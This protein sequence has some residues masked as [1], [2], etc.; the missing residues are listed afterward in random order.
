M[1]KVSVLVL[2]ILIVSAASLS[3][4]TGKAGA[5]AAFMQLNLS[6]RIMGMGGAFGAV[7]DD[8]L[9]M[10]YN[11]AGA[12]QLKMNAVS[13]SYRHMDFDRKLGNVCAS[14]MA[15]EEA[16]IAVG[17]I[18]AGDGDWVGRDAEGSVTNEDL[19]YSDN[20]LAV[21]FARTF[22]DMIM[23]GA[24]GKY[25]ITK[26]ANISSNTVGFDVGTMM[27]LNRMNYLENSKLFDQI[28]IGLTVANL[29]ATHRW[30]TGDYWAAYGGTGV[31]RDESFS[32]AIKGGVSALML[33]SSTL[34]AVDVVKYED[35]DIRF[36]AGVEHILMNSLAL[37]AGYAD[38]RVSA[39]AGITKKYVYY[40]LKFDYAFVTGIDGEAA[41]HL[42]TVG[43]DFR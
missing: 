3:A 11:P 39:G 40:S 20:T 38:G 26:V 31:S 5:P 18:Y 6:A 2:L 19:S 4:D 1:K 7:S 36:Y 12:A 24:T 17:W 15:R 33:D 42:F 43:F 21:A 23:V 16:T 35:Q 10:F 25:F 9:A 13:A 22:G 28:R 32:I 41:N 8:A 30:S 29:G 37:R 34:F 14:F 27:S